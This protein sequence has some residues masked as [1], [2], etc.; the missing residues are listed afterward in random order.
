MWCKVLVWMLM[1]ALVLPP[2]LT[3]CVSR[4]RDYRADAPTSG[5]S[6][7]RAPSPALAENTAGASSSRRDAAREENSR[8]RGLNEALFN[9]VASFMGLPGLAPQRGVDG[10]LDEGLGFH[11]D[12]TTRRAGSDN[13][14]DGQRARAYQRAG[15]GTGPGAG[16]AGLNGLAP[17]YGDER[18]AA[19][20]HDVDYSGRRDARNGSRSLDSLNPFDMAVERGLNYGMGLLNSAG[21]AALSGLTDNGRARLNFQMNKDGRLSGE[22]DVLLPLYDGR[23]TTLFTQLGAR[24]MDV[25][26]GE[27]DGSQRWIG[28]FGLGQRWF[29]LAEDLDNAGNLMLGYNVFFDNDFTRSHQ[30]GGAGVEAQYDWF[31]VAANYYTPLSGWKASRDFDGDFVEERPARGW[32]AR[33][34]AYLP[35]YRNVALTGAYA[36]WYGDHVAMYGSSDDLEKDPKVWSYGVEYTPVPLVSGFV[37]QRSTER[38]K[39]DTEFGL[40]FTYHFGMPWDEQVSHAKVAELR[41][42]SGSRHE[43]VDRE[44]RIILEYRAKNASMIEYLGPNGGAVNEFVFR[45]RNGFDEYKAGQTVRVT[46]SGVT[47]AAAPALPETSLLARL[48]GAIADFFSTPTAHA[49]DFSQSYTSDGQGRFIVRIGSS[50]AGPVALRIQAGDNS[51]SFTVNVVANLLSITTASPLP[52]AV[53]GTAYSQPFT[54]TGGTAPYSFGVTNGAL[55][56]GMALNN[57]KLEGT[58]TV[59]GTY[60]F[61]VTATDS[62][63]PTAA[64]ASKEFKLTVGAAPLSITT[65][66]PLPNA[67]VGTTYSQ[68]FVATGG[69]GAYTFAVADGSSLP[70]GLL[71]SNNGTLTGTPTADG[72]YTFTVTVTDSA[73]PTAATASKEFSLTVGA[74]PLSITTAS[75]PDATVGTNYSQTFVAT[76]GTSPYSFAVADGSSLPSGLLLSNNGTL[77][78]TPTAD[79]TYTFTVTVT[80]SAS[81]AATASKEFSLTV[82]A[83]PLSI[84]TT[85]PLSSATKGLAYSQTFVATGGTGAYTFAVAD[86]SSLPS[87]LSLSNDGKLTGTPTADGTYTFTVTMTDSASPAVT[88]S[89][90]FSLT[91]NPGVYTLTL[92]PTAGGT[93]SNNQ[94]TGK[95]S[96]TLLLD[97][98]PASNK[99]ITW[100][101]TD[102]SN[103]SKAVVAG[104][105]TKKTGLAWG[106]SAPG[107]PENEL[108]T[109]TSSTTNASGIAEIS[110]TDVMGE[111][112]VTVQ[113]TAEGLTKTAT[114][115]FPNGPLAVFAGPPKGTYYWGNNESAASTSFPAANQCG[116]SDS[117]IINFSDYPPANFSTIYVSASKLPTVEQLVAVG[118]GSGRGKGAAYAAGWPPTIPYWTGTARVWNYT[119][120]ADDLIL[121]DST[122]HSHVVTNTFQTVC[123]P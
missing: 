88:A 60:T 76:G 113:A 94:S 91:V 27:D 79:G 96:A 22:G 33:L 72:T 20:W 52:D 75:L 83:A 118:K 82:G 30:R 115:S 7:N 6:R 63:G 74:V 92:T 5:L 36:Q 100:L 26:G 90:A 58:P 84:T 13:D 10:S 59:T 12:G 71:L 37:K 55:P 31:H 44:N 51:Q 50:F 29:P 105:K 98:N 89:K 65:T 46:A 87:D 47:L 9:T 103:N 42:V 73:G 106:A 104:Y 43:F 68:T 123:L 39:T 101:V 21:E 67:T 117:E 54:A 109:T 19:L 24:S 48:G 64:T 116:A 1:A 78:G 99:T 107:T 18:T 2:S 108:T 49:A 110:L 40:Q 23:Y 17:S 25:N 95:V 34:K 70:S 121:S 119:Y 122:F 45:I 112:V 120:Q 14:F 11:Q 38:G 93:F 102:A 80:D 66:S 85:S 62:A 97:G 35:F 4:N 111:R 77:T 56:A 86:G 41:S 69:T 81:P 3:G 32:D 28:N 114:V 57:G 53:N 16:M 8:P 61:T 15:L